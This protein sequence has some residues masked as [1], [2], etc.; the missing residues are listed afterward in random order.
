VTARREATAA[1]T[2]PP[3]AEG[4]LRALQVE[5]GLARTTLAEYWR[6]LHHATCTTSAAGSPEALGKE[7]A[8]LALAEL[9]GLGP[10]RARA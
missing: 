8:A 9:A 4:Y 3:L 2:L 6:D 10:R 5:R 1:A 7:A